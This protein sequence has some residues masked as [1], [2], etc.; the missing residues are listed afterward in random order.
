MKLIRKRNAL[1]KRAKRTKD[2]SDLAIYK[3]FRNRIVKSLRNGNFR[4]FNSLTN[5]DH[6]SFWK[7]VKTL[8]K[9]R[10]TIPTLQQGDLIASTDKEKAD[11]LNI[12]FASC[13]NTNELP[14]SEDAY[15]SHVL[16]E[17]STVTPDKVFH[18]LN[19]LDT[20]KAND[21]DNMS[22]QM[23]KATAHSISVPLARLFTLSLSEGR[24]PKMWKIAGVVP[25]PK[26]SSKHNPCNYRP[27]SLLSVVSK[28]LERIVQSLLWEHLLTYAP[29]LDKQWGF[30]KG[31]S[32][33]TALLY[34]THDWF[35]LLDQQE[36]VMCIFFDF[37][38]AFNTVPRR[39]LL[40]KLCEIESRPLLLSW[41]C[42]Y[43][44]G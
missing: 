28:H 16:Y 44:S 10:E 31:K 4:Y 20:N 1:F 2:H 27:I 36:D 38:N 35:T 23:L 5:A 24:F 13:W 32:T 40:D 30:Q 39:K 8:N 25:I 6:K 43:L 19:S 22:A 29:I 37:K 9:N 15:G 21:P 34:A 26:S 7:C 18:L 3:S 41:L 14:L 12:F 42:S 11:M 33:T 17:D